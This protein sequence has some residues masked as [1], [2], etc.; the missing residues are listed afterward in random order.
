MSSGQFTGGII[1][2]LPSAVRAADTSVVGLDIIDPVDGA[3]NRH[4]VSEAFKGLLAYLNITAVPGVDTVKLQL[5]EQEPVSGT[6]S[7]LYQTSVQVGAVLVKMLVYPG[8]T[9]VAD[10]AVLVH[11]ADILPPKWRFKVV[12]SGAGNFTYSLVVVPLN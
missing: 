7:T 6:Y 9:E 11:R 3:G 1:I 2:A 4:G 12:H 8:I 5:Q 10:T